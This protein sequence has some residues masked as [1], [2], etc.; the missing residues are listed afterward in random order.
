MKIRECFVSNSSSSNFILAVKDEN[1]KIKCTIYIDPT[2]FERIIYDEADLKE[3]Y[4]DKH[5]NYDPY[6]P[7]SVEDFFKIYPEEK[8]KYDNCLN[9]LKKGKKLIICEISNYGD[10]ELF[11]YMYY[12]GGAKKCLSGVEVIDEVEG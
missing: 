4:K 9:A 11:R 10:N 5:L 7:T 1:T 2:D 6:H 3:Y 8:K 12:G